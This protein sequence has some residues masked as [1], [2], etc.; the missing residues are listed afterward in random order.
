MNDVRLMGENQQSD[1]C[2]AARS[3]LRRKLE[4]DYYEL[5]QEKFRLQSQLDG[6]LGESNYD[7]A[8]EPYRSTY[9]RL[10]PRIEEIRELIDKYPHNIQIKVLPKYVSTLAKR[11]IKEDF[12]IAVTK[13]MDGLG[14]L[15]QTHKPDRFYTEIA[16]ILKEEDM[17]VS[18]LTSTDDNLDAVFRYLVE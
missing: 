18:E 2:A 1:P 4:N 16:K 3:R 6:A 17:D 10:N 15:V 13:Q 9:L 8:N 11:L 5:E 12:V 7:S 14:L